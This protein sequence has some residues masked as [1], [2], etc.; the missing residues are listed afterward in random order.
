MK[1]TFELGEVFIT[2]SAVGAL[3]CQAI[4][5][6]LERHASGNWGDVCWDDWNRNGLAM[7]QGQRIISVYHDLNGR[8]FWVVTSANRRKTTLLLPEDYQPYHPQKTKTA[9]QTPNH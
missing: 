3:S 1:T 9:K 4:F 7:S 6:A 5:S 8:L 2:R